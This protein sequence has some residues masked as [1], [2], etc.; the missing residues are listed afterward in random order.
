MASAT[1]NGTFRNYEGG[2]A[3]LYNVVWNFGFGYTLTTLNGNKYHQGSLTA[4]YLLS[5]RTDVYVE[6][7]FQHAVG[8][9]AHADII[10]MTGSSGRNQ[11]LLRIGMRHR[12]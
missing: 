9:T 4:D 2:F 5:A 8:D 11:L 3:W 10:S 6:S 7:I 12:F 1:A